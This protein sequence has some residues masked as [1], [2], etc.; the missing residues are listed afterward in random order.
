MERLIALPGLV[1]YLVVGGLVAV[2]DALFIGFVV[3]GETAAILGGVVAGFGRVS[4]TGMI[5]LVSAM[6]I[7]SDS[8]GYEIG[9]RFGSRLL[10][11]RSLRK[12][13]HTVH[14]AQEMM[15]RRGGQAIIIG[16]FVAY[17]RAIIPALA[18]MSRMPYPRFLFYNSVG[19]ILWGVSVVSAGYLAGSS[20]RTLDKYLGR[21]SA[22]AFGIAVVVGL[23]VWRVRAHRRHADCGDEHHCGRGDERHC[24]R[25]DAPDSR[26]GGRNHDDLPPQ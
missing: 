1:V 12:R 7:F 8:L 3:P 14:R 16:R 22:V 5:I 9:R 25:G 13:E 18:G 15:A 23:I 24:D 17:L 10:Q 4:L 19:G 20:Y 26:D 21:G 11:T 6:A 2:E